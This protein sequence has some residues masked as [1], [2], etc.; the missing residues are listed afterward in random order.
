[1][2]TDNADQNQSNVHADQEQHSTTPLQKLP[3][4]NSVQ[5]HPHV[6]TVKKLFDERL[7]AQRIYQD[8]VEQHEYKGGYDSVKRYVRKLRKGKRGYVDHLEHLPG[9]EAQVDFGKSTCVI[10]LKEKTVKSGS[11]K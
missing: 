4:T 2:P 7:T 11:L 8:L 9:R 3:S 5:L 6:E 1:M 10:K